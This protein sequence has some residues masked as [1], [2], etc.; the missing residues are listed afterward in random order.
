MRLRHAIPALALLSG[1]AAHAQQAPA[2]SLKYTTVTYYGD[3]LTGYVM[4]SRTQYILGRNTRMESRDGS[5]KQFGPLRAT[6][7][8]DEQRILYQ[9]DLAAKV[10]TATPPGGHK[11]IPVDWK[12]SGR[13]H[14]IHI[15]T[16]DTGERRYM[17]GYTARR[18][19]TR[20]TDTVSPPRDYPEMHSETDGWYID[21]RAWRQLYKPHPGVVY[22]GTEGEQDEIRVTCQGARETGFPIVDKTARTYERVIEFSEDRLDPALF[23]P[24]A[25]FK[26]APELP[27]APLDYQY[28]W[29]L[30]VRLRWFLVMD[31]L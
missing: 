10:Y 26:L 7:W 17:F 24:P 14:T 31:W 12:P 25:D 3:V 2:P 29:S 16:V 19:K 22:A 1:L 6:I 23:L 13:T 20:R 28:P 30:G 18:V 11:M 4:S 21:S 8:N 27:A 5:G 15:E 9:L